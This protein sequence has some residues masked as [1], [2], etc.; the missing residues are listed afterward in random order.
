MEC[1]KL[2]HTCY[3]GLEV[4]LSDDAYLENFSPCISHH[5]LLEMDD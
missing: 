2:G 5:G 4:I 3:G 1:F